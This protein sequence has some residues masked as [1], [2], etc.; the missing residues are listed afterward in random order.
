MGCGQKFQSAVV[1]QKTK[2]SEKPFTIGFY[3]ILR[4][5]NIQLQRIVFMYILI[6]TKKLI[7]S[8]YCK[9]M[10][11]TYILAWR[12]HHKNMNWKKHGTK[13]IISSSVI[14]PCRIFFCPNWNKWSRDTKSCVG[15]SV[16]NIP[17]TCMN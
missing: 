14:Q 7:P 15:V 16:A 2:S 13:K 9:F 6:A 5:W 10:Y 17:N 8:C 11:K 12:F 1:I 4:L 3:I